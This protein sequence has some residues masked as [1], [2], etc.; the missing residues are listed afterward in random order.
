MLVIV[1]YQMGNLGS[2]VNMLKKAGIG[3]VLSSDPDVIR[4]AT[5]LILPGVGAFDNGMKNLER[6]K[7]VSVLNEQVIDKRIPILG[8]CLGMQLLSKQSEEGYLPGLSWL[9]A[10]TVR[11]HFTK[12]QNSLKIPHMGWNLVDIQRPH[13]LLKGLEEDNRFYFVHSFH[14]VCANEKTIVG[15]TT[16]GNPFTSVVAHGNVMGVQFHPE[17]SHRF[18]MQLLK[19]YAEWKND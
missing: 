4:R 11:F 1:D 6:L 5:R 17:K 16:Y 9:D 2:I 8:L 19:N 10:Q 12:E 15:E 7:L 18:G 14:V 13:P 3:S